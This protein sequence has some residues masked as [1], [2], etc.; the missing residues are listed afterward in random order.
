MDSCCATIPLSPRAASTTIY[1]YIEIDQYT[2]KINIDDLDEISGYCARVLSSSVYAV[3]TY[4]SAGLGADLTRVAWPR[5]KQVFNCDSSNVSTSIPLRPDI[6][7]IELGCP[8][9]LP[10][11][12]LVDHPVDLLVV[13]QGD[14]AMPYWHPWVTPCSAESKPSIIFEFWPP[15]ASF[16]EEGPVS[17]AWYTRWKETG[18]ITRCKLICVADLGSS[19]NQEWL[20]V[21]RLN[22]TLDHLDHWDWPDL[23]PP[24]HRPMANCL[25]PFGVPW[26]AYQKNPTRQLPDRYIPHQDLDLMPAFAG[27]YIQTTKG[28]RRLLHDELSKGLGVPSTWLDN[29][30]PKGNLVE[31]T[32]GVHMF[33]YLTSALHEPTKAIE[34]EEPSDVGDLEQAFITVNK[35]LISDESENPDSD[36]TWVPPDLAIDSPWFR[37]RTKNLQDAATKCFGEDP[38]AVIEEGLIALEHHRSNYTATHPDPKH[39]QLLWWEFPPEHWEALRHGSTMNFLAEPPL[40]MHDNAPMDA[41]QLKIACQFV[42]KLVALG[43][44]IPEDPDD[45][46]VSNAPMFLL[47]KPGQPGEWHI[48]ADL[49]AGGQNSVVGPDPTVFPKSAHILAQMYTGGYSAVVDASKFFYQF[50]VRKEDQKYLGCIHPKTGARL[51]YCKLPMGAGNSP[52]LAGRYGSSFLRLLRERCKL[53]QG[54]LRPNLWLNSLS[55]AGDYDGTAGHGMVLDGDDGEPAVLVW[56]HCDD[57]LIHGS[58]KEK[59]TRALSAFLDLAVDCG[60]LCHPGKLSPPAQVV[61]YTGF[62]FDTSAEPALRIPVNKREKALA[63]LDFIVKHRERVSRLGL[64]I[65]TGILESL[66][67]ATPAHIGRAYLRKLYE[68]IHPEGWDE[69]DLVY[70]SY[71]TLPDDAIQDLMWWRHALLSDTKQRCRLDK[72]G[73]MVPMFGDGS[74]TGTGG[75]VKYP[76]EVK[77]VLTDENVT[78][79]MWLGAWSPHVFHHTSNWKEA[80]TLLKSLQRAAAN[81]EIKKKVRG[82][83]FF[84]FT[85]NMVTYYIVQGG[86][87]KA[88]ELHKLVLKIKALEM[89]LGCHL[90]VVHVP[91]TAMISEGT[92]GLSRGMWMTNLQSRPTPEVLMTEIFQAITSTP[93]LGEWAK[94]QAGIPSSTPLTYR[95]WAVHWDPHEVFDQLTFWCPPPEVAYQLLY[96]LLTCW[97]EKPLT[98]SALLLI[99]RILQRQWS[100]V[101]RQLIE[102]GVYQK[103]CIPELPKSHLSIPSV[104]VLIPT[105]VRTLPRDRLDPSSATATERW[106]RKQAELLRG[107]PEFDLSTI[108]ASEMQIF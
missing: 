32:V 20:V 87:S 69:D 80:R 4:G 84:Y 23:P 93:R 106:H 59:T 16:S 107:L 101:S 33:E 62:L 27:S 99:P 68:I 78:L 73:I 64:S 21:A 3:D 61:K 86:A 57:F 51:V 41:A 108:K 53:F 5:L 17:K 18:Y 37:E 34:V 10:K 85:D 15:T 25:R 24:A 92:D 104:L 94:E 6:A 79:E 2:N 50:P 29:I 19:V 1:H 97:T 12:I 91:G 47:P 70:F 66:S 48:L 39:L 63:I 54:T 13:G 14:I 96:F 100:R 40:G 58:T 65:L 77:P 7:G 88:P 36:F 105:H 103:N 74:G 43:V 83:T 11:S 9:R 38:T 56:A 82:T 81:A 90:E 55:G 98:T 8:Q 35:L 75:T 45:P 26:K 31:Q 44:L 71:A 49:R 76:K 102:V 67:E 60:M 72:A 42:D 52:S 46:M 89:E 30:Y 28:I 95:D 22:E